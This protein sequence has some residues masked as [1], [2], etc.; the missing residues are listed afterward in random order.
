MLLKK[1]AE[2]RGGARHIGGD[3]RATHGESS[4]SPE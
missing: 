2:F 4:M 3:R 1:S